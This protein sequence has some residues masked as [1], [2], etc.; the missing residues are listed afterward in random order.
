MKGPTIREVLDAFRECK[1]EDRDLAIYEAER[2]AERVEA[3]LREVESLDAGAYEVIA[4]SRVRD[5][6]NGEQP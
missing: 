1:G 4:L 6:L 3:V 2:L 5:L